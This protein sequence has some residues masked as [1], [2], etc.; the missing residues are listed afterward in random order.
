M[1]CD[2]TKKEALLMSR[3]SNRAGVVALGWLLLLNRPSTPVAWAQEGND[4]S[5]YQPI[6][7]QPT[8]SSQSGSSATGQIIGY[9]PIPTSVLGGVAAQSTTVPGSSNPA[10]QASQGPA[11]SKFPVGYPTGVV[12]EE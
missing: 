4:Q 2:D 12:G 3:I 5:S 6:Q 7:A 11:G 1:C 8:S 9:Q 10:G